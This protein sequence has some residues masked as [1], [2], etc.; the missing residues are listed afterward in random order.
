LSCTAATANATRPPATTPPATTQLAWHR[1]GIGGM[2]K[3]FLYRHSLWVSPAWITMI[4]VG[5]PEA[6]RQPVPRSGSN[7]TAGGISTMSI[8]CL[9]MPVT[10]LP[11]TA[12]GL[13]ASSAINTFSSR[14]PRR[15]R[16]TLGWWGDV[17][18]RWGASWDSIGTETYYEQHI[19]PNPES[20]CWSQAWQF[21]YRASGCG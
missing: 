2:K 15:T 1:C 13:P 16:P 6:P 20:S 3:S 8:P 12:L 4:T 17:L 9:A 10:M 11:K 21:D 14:S 18:L 5:P 19:D 7:L